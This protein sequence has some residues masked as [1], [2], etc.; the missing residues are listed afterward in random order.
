MKT[1]RWVLLGAWT[2]LVYAGAVPSGFVLD[3]HSA[4]V[5][6]PVVQGE[7]SAVEAFTRD[8][9]GLVPPGTIGTYRPLAVLTFVLDARVGG[10]APWVF[11][12]TNVLLHVLAVLALFG[13]WRQWAGDTTAW[14]A[15]ALFATLAAPAEA[16]HSIVGRADVLAALFGL[17]GWA[18]HRTPG[19]R[20]AMLAAVCYTLALFSKESALLYPLVWCLME[21]L[22]T[23]RWRVL[24]WG[25]LGVYASVT[26]LG[27]GA[28]KHAL[29]TFL[30]ATIGDM[31][32]P[33]VTASWS[34]RVLGAADIFWSQYLAGIA[35]PLRRLYMCSAPA[36]A[37]VGVD[38]AG[39]WLGLGA[40]G[41]LV[42]LALGTWRRAPLVSAGVAWFLLLFLPISNLLVVG[43]SVY[44]ERLLYAPL[45]GASVALAHAVSLLAARLPRPALAWGMLVALGAGN[46][47]AVQSR[48]ADWRDGTSLALQAIEVQP[49]STVLQ[50]IA[51]E[52][53][54]RL[55]HWAEAEQCARDAIA[56]DADY[57]RPYGLLGVALDQQGRTAEAQAMLERALSLEHSAEALLNLVRFHARHGDPR[58]ALALL[59]RE[60]RNRTP[61]PGQRALA[62]ELRQ[63]L[64]TE[65]R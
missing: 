19:L 13:V 56:L 23:G 6:S 2:A 5:G 62:E 38:S 37:P 30:G 27:L 49:R 3:D 15:A 45:M 10:G 54:V 7:V 11:H 64:A 32:N 61:T 18:A 43:P 58:R 35:N 59:E 9:W 33:L 34:G 46:A 44:G 36:C 1:R 60:T 39:A 26:A 53:W 25:R 40:L 20:A 28:R 51:A 24:P 12:L 65:A 22:R 21:A 29:G 14:A 63:Q 57:G 42:A 48:H 31:T 4:V 41:L 50:M 55:G 16:V 17:L 52:A 8:Y 47:L